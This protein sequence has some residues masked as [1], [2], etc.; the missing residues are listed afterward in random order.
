[1]A[2][3]RQS[4]LKVGRSREIS[5]NKSKP[6][7][8]APIAAVEYLEAALAFTR[9]QGL[10]MAIAQL[11]LTNWPASSINLPDNYRRAARRA[12]RRSARHHI[13]ASPNL[14]GRRDRIEVRLEHRF[15]STTLSLYGRFS[16]AVQVRVYELAR[17]VA[18]LGHLIPVW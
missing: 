3:S 5:R 4:S 17:P 10:G 13:A 11:D 8:L 14:N 16:A 2:T 9:N 15:L 18:I 1:M 7:W 6:L 12:S